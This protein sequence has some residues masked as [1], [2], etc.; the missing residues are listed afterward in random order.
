[1]EAA[2]LEK[3]GTV[4]LLRERIR[5]LQAEP[6]RSGSVLRTGVSAFDALLPGGG[7]P[8]GQGLELWGEAASGRTSLALRA[9]AS[10]HREGRLCAWVDGPAELYPPCA[11]ALGVDLQ[12]LLVVRPKAPGQ[13]IW[14]AVQL[15]R[16]GAFG[17]V[18]LDLTHTGLRLSLAESKRLIDAAGKSGASLL[19]LTP[20][21]APGEGMTRLRTQARGPEGLTVEVVRGKQGATGEHTLIGWE[22]L[23]PQ[24]APR[25][26][27]RGAVPQRAPEAPVEL[28]RFV[29][30]KSYWKRDGGGPVGIQGQRPGRDQ[31]LPKLGA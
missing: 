24:E 23:S 15:L 10:A 11:T 19:L 29:R 21:D 18:V 7:L 27:Y 22:E 12:R 17:C 31:A 1:M 9:V 26:R 20:P 25:Y 6:R 5:R 4:E 2:K 8:L 16:S 14:S 13:L 28:P 3:A 30:L